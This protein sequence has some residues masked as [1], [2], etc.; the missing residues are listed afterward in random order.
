MAVTH[1]HIDD[2]SGLVANDGSDAFPNLEHLYIP[3]EEASLFDR[4]ERLSRFCQRCVALGDGCSGHPHHRP[5]R[6]WPL[7]WTY[8][9]RGLERR[10]QAADLGRYRARAIDPVRQA[11]RYLGV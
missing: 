3:Q 11:E 7:A 5:W 2:V 9:V 10:S 6:R 4:S 1:T 8:G